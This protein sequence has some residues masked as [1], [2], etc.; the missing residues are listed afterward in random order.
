MSEKQNN[1]AAKE[2]TAEQK[3]KQKKIKYAIAKVA[4]AICVVL[5]IVLTVFELGLTYRILKAADVDGTE[6]SVAEYNWLYTTNVYQVYS[7]YYQSYGN[8]ASYFFNPGASLSEQKYNDEKS[9]AEQIKE[10]TDNSLIEMT[11]LYNAGM[12]AGYELSEEDKETVEAEWEA[13]VETAKTNG[14]SANE[15][16]EMSYGRGVNEKVFK[17]MYERYVYSMSYA[18]EY[19]NSQKILDGDIDEYYNENKDSFDN[20]TYKYFLASGA[21][22]ED[23]DEKTAMAEAKEKAEAILSGEDKTELNESRNIAKDNVNELFRDWL[24]DSSRKTGDKDIFEGTT[25][26]YVVEFVSINDLHYNTVNVRH[27]LVS[28][29]K[30][31]DEASLKEALKKAEEYKAEWDKNPT[32]DNFAELAKKYSKDGSAS[33]GGLYENISKGQMVTEF[34]DWCFDEARKPGDSGIVE[35]TYGYHVMFFSSEGVEY[36]TYAVENAVKADRYVKFLD[37]ITKD[38]E[39]NHLVGYNFVGKHFN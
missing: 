36:Y 17:D 26:Y 30:A 21:K 2:L 33:V 31:N 27:I 12:E 25:G 6:Y 11:K 13:L 15:Y 1:G 5:C 16:A 22:T 3:A 24:F 39:A 4:V 29:E 35:T 18:E 19:M 9:W 32:E 8:L 34:E 14:F 28:P 37:E 23:K 10:N 38:V 20:V 7:N